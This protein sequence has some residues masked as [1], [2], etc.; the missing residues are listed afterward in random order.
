MSK[1]Q[2]K[3]CEGDHTDIC[4]S[5]VDELPDSAETAECKP[6]NSCNENPLSTPAPA[7][8][9]VPTNCSS[10]GAAPGFQTTSEGPPV[11]EELKSLSNDLCARAEANAE[12]MYQLEL[13]LEESFPVAESA[14][15]RK[16]ASDLSTTSFD[17]TADEHGPEKVDWGGNT[18]S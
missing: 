8:K 9:K 16:M 3:L 10:E 6:D 2:G 13:G 7:N 5:R 11:R 15:W 4:F 1:P 12:D 18:Y 17:C 14:R